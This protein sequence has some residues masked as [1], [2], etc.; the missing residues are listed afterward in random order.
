MPSRILIADDNG[1]ARSALADIIRS[2]GE[3]WAI[4]EADDGLSAVKLA[5]E[6]KPDLV[7]LDVRMP[8]VDGMRAA[9]EIRALHPDVPIL[10]YTILAN[11][12]LEAAALSAGFQGVIEKPDRTALLSA[13]RKHLPSKSSAPRQSEPSHGTAPA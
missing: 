9:R 13:I 8:R 10:F 1:G 4:C 7:I 12:T 6:Q 11:P 3:N 5:S 2:A